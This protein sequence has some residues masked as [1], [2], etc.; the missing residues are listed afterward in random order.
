MHPCCENSEF[1]FLLLKGLTTRIW[2]F[3]KGHP[4][5]CDGGA[6]L[7]TAVRETLEETGLEAGRDYDIIG[8]SIRYGKRPYWIG[9]LREG[10]GPVTLSSSEHSEAAWFSREEMEELNSNSDVRSW[11]KKSQGPCSQFG[12]ITAFISSLRP[13]PLLQH[14]IDTH[15]TSLDHIVS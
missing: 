8:D 12:R 3:S 13:R 5:T 7:R 15:S 4:E 11:I 9:L 10:A 1:Q 2:S 6:P 14:T